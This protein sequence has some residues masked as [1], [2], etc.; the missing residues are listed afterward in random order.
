MTLTEC[1]RPW[2]GG[3]VITGVVA[4]WASLQLQIW[5]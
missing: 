5:W 4:T 1:N 3:G 2:H